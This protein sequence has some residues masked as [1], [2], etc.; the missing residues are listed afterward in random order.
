MADSKIVYA[1][2]PIL[3]FVIAH[4]RRQKLFFCVLID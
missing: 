3:E 1:H 4:G 2:A